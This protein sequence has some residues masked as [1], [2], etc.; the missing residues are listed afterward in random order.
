[1]VTVCETGYQL[2]TTVCLVCLTVGLLCGSVPG[3]GRRTDR[4]REDW[5]FL[6]SALLHFSISIM[7][8]ALIVLLSILD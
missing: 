7:M 6:P 1:M 4:R 5:N 3:E 2:V 8:L